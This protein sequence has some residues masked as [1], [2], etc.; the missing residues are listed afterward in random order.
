MPVVSLVDA[1]GAR[2]DTNAGETAARLEAQVARLAG[3]FDEA[4]RTFTQINASAAE[5]L[6]K[7]IESL[8]GMVDEAGGRLA[9]ELAATSDGYTQSLDKVR[10]EMAEALEKSSAE[11][12]ERLESRSEQAMAH[13]VAS[14]ERLND[15]L[16]AVQPAGQR[17]ARPAAARPD[18][19]GASRHARQRRRSLA[20]PA[21]DR[22]RLCRRGRH[23][24]ASARQQR[25]R[26]AAA[27]T[28]PRRA[29]A[30]GRPAQRHRGSSSPNSP[31]CWSPG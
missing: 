27:G 1:A 25:R 11:M 28:R 31:G 16:S 10:A 20:Q 23:R 3:Q 29:P 30:L 14:T 22:S 8:V 5:G 4:G 19:A 13:I 7:Q 2:A 9:R 12:A 17:A 24:A 15:T 18:D 6:G 21:S 26:A